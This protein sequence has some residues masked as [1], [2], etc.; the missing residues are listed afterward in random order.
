MKILVIGQGG[1]EHALAWKLSQS[2]KSEIVFVAPGNG[3]TSTEEKCLNVSIKVNDFPG[4]KKFIIEEQIELVVIGPEDPLVNGLVDYLQD[5]NIL[6]FGPCSNGARLEGSKIF[7]KKFLFENDIPTG[8]ASFFS[9][10]ESAYSFLD[11]CEYPI[12]LKADG[13][14]AGKGVLVSKNVK[15][16]KEWVD[17]VMNNALFGVAGENILIEE[18]LYGTE[19]SFMGVMT[20]REFIPFEEL[21]DVHFLNK[22]VKAIIGHHCAKV[23]NQTLHS[24]IELTDTS[25][26]LKSKPFSIPGWRPGSLNKFQRSTGFVTVPTPTTLNINS[27]KVLARDL[28]LD[29]FN[30]PANSIDI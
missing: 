10:P 18:C 29:F 9:D 19:L 4:I 5:L 28:F 30:I 7:S 17:S 21:F 15:E 3:G 22:Y 11:N 23:C 27:K 2:K 6:I 12:V 13:L 25:T 8:K 20:P 14:A 1:R 26:N 16:A 24:F